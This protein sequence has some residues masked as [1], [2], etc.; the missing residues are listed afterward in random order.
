MAEIDERIDRHYKRAHE[1]LQAGNLDLYW[2]EI[3][4]IVRLDRL[5]ERIGE[6][7]RVEEGT[8]RAGGR[9]GA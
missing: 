7:G 5:E 4:R 6:V 2:R 1:A 8:A 9:A 3:D